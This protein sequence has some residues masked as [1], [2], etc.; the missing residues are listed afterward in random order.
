MCCILW[1]H[2][3]LQAARR[4]VDTMIEVANEMNPEIEITQ[5]LPTGRSKVN[6]RVTV[7][8]SWDSKLIDVPLYINFTYS[9]S[10]TN[11][12]H[13]FPA[14]ILVA[15][16]PCMLLAGASFERARVPYRCDQ[17]SMFNLQRGW[18]AWLLACVDTRVFALSPV[19]FDLLNWHPVSTICVKDNKMTLRFSKITYIFVCY[20][21]FTDHG[22]LICWC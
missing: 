15:M 10:L 6:M 13:R 8:N 16:Y 1:C 20:N 11:R 17:C 21:L 4:A 18:T 5:I 3:C 7:N 14:S 9:L 19:V 2:A 22:W 12:T